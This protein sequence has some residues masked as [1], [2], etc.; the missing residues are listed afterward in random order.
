MNKSTYRVTVLIGIGMILIVV[1]AIALLLNKAIQNQ[2]RSLGYSHD[3]NFKDVD[4]LIPVIPE[5]KP[6]GF[7]YQKGS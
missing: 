7:E 5:S 1:V 2:E 6:I 4:S 3:K